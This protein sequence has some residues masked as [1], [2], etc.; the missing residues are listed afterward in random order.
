[1]AKFISASENKIV[2]NGVMALWD[3]E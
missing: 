3:N 1:M 2:K